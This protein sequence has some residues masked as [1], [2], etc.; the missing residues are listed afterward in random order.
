MEH[1]LIGR[2]KLADATLPEQAN[3]QDAAVSAAVHCRVNVHTPCKN[4]RAAVTNDLQLQAFGSRSSLNTCCT[5]LYQEAG[6]APLCQRRV[7]IWTS[8]A[9]EVS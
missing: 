6:S 2:A 8:A 7:A 9:D 1:Y 5:R 3:Q 4:A